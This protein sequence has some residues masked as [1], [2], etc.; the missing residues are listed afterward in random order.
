M[1]VGEVRE[2]LVDETTQAPLPG[3]ETY[4]FTLP[5]ILQAA[6]SLGKRVIYRRLTPLVVE[7]NELVLGYT[8]LM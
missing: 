2:G 6:A 4:A 1:L 8:P 5:S 3:C 7:R